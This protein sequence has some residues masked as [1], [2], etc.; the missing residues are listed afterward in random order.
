MG[1]D[2]QAQ[3]DHPALYAVLC[4]LGAAATATA[5]YAY[6]ARTSSR[7]EADWFFRRT[8]RNMLAG[9]AAAAVLAGAACLVSYVSLTAACTLLLAAGIILLAV[10]VPPCMLIIGYAGRQARYLGRQ[11]R[12]YLDR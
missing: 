2:Q 6:L 9:A 5:A 4:G 1:G 7:Q 11:Y 8:G 12:G 10:Y 3:Q